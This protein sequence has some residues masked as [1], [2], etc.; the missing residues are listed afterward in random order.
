MMKRGKATYAFAPVW[1]IGFSVGVALVKSVGER[2]LVERSWKINR[3]DVLT[4]LGGALLGY[5][6]FRWKHGNRTEGVLTR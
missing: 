3:H 2:Y 4:A 5:I 1:V 6:S